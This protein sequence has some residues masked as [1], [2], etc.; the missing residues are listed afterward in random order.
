M[1]S[2][3]KTEQVKDMYPIKYF[4]RRRK[5]I[6]EAKDSKEMK[7]KAKT[8]EDEHVEFSV[9]LLQTLLLHLRLLDEEQMIENETEAKIH[10]ISISDLR[11]KEAVYSKDER[12]Y[13]DNCKTSIFD[14]HRSCTLCTFDLCLICCRELRNGQL[15]GEEVINER[16]NQTESNIVAKPVVREW[17]RFGWHAESNGRIPCPKVSDEYNHGF[18]ELRSV[19]GQNFIT[20]LLCKAN[21]LAQRHELGTLDNCCTCSRL[22]KKTDVRYHEPVIVSHA[23]DSA[24]GLSW[25]PSVMSR[26]LCQIAESR[27]P[28][29]LDMKAID[30]LDLCEVNVLTHI[31]EVKLEV[32]GIENLKEK[33]LEQDQ[34]DGSDGA[35]WDIFQRQDVPKLQEYLR[36]HFRE[37]RHIHCRPLKQVRQYLLYMDNAS[38]EVKYFLVGIEPWTFIQ[39]LG[40][41]VFIPAGCP[42]QVR[43]LKLCNKVAMDFV[44]PESVGVCFGLTEEFRTLPI[45]HG[46]AEDKLEVKMMTIY[47]MQDVIRKLERTRLADKGSVKV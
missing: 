18:L 24:S 11:V 13:C 46:C 16:V 45:N 10:G 31:A 28:Q 22:D 42:H 8:K 20:D 12:V 14:Y 17:S 38:A 5:Q 43:N 29:H 3:R 40:E 39:K 34:G 35:V 27:H 37:F 7:Q 30:C 41:A 33:Q 15:L 6:I 1:D 25:E 32:T 19:L 23:I 36:K 44:S 4:R 47:A 26:A 21:E 9:Y 2:D